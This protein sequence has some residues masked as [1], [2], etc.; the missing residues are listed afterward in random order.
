MRT[1]GG[2]LESD[3]KF[4]GIMKLKIHLHGWIWQIK[5]CSICYGPCVW[6]EMIVV[7]KSQLKNN[8]LTTLM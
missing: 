6:L 8:I 3:G 4:R 1:G 7:G 5:S 2:N